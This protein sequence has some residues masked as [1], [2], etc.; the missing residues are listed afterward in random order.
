M[1]NSNERDEIVE[2]CVRMAWLADHRR[3]DRFDEVFADRVHVD[4]TSIGGGEAADLRREEL[5]SSWRATLGELD[6]TQHLT[7]NHLVSIDGERAECTASFQATHVRANPQGGPL[8][9]LGG[10]YRFTLEL[11]PKG[12]RI[13]AVT[14]TAVWADGNQQL[15]ALAT[16]P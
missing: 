12:W 2:T 5:V 8:W 10:D 3:W 16:R 7:G 14:M 6:A 9:V 13:D 4:Y 15:M 11:T 1:V